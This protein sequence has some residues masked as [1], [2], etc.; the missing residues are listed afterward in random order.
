MVRIQ[1]P[2]LNPDN[3]GEQG[4]YITYRAAN[5]QMAVFQDITGVYTGNERF[6]RAAAIFVD[7]RSYIEI[8]GINVLNVKRWVV[9]MQSNHI[10]V[11]NSDFKGGTGWINC[12]LGKIGEGMKIQNNY[13]QGGTI[14]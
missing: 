8:Y 3:S 11:K 6:E 10:T 7:N 14:W 13:F 1:L 12:R 9:G 5:K 2:R 4:A